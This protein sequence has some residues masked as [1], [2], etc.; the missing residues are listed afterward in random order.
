MPNTAGSVIAGDSLDVFWTV[1][2]GCAEDPARYD[3]ATKFLEFFYSDGLYEETYTAM[4]G[5]STL[6]DRSRDQNSDDTVLLEVN[7]AHDSAQQRIRGYVGDENT[8]PGFEK[9]LL[10]LLSR[11]CAGELSV[12]QTQELSA[13]YWE[14][15]LKQEVSYGP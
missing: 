14:A 3:A 6:S 12:A 9:Q 2:A 10:T 8:P 13:A 7:R 15:C 11:M 1:T 5:F 4:A